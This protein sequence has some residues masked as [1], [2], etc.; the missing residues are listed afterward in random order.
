[1]PS[2]LTLGISDVANAN[3][4]KNVLEKI[5][6]AGAYDNPESV[7]TENE[8]VLYDAI[9]ANIAAETVRAENTSHLAKAGQIT[10][11]MIPFVMDIAIGKGLFSGMTKAAQKGVARGVVRAL[12]N[13]KW[14]RVL[15]RQTGNLI[16]GFA[17]SAAIAAIA[18]S[19]YKHILEEEAKVDP[20]SLQLTD[21]GWKV[22]K[23]DTQTT[24]AAIWNGY[25]GNF[26]E[27]FTETGGLTQFAAGF[28]KASPLGRLISKTPIGMLSRIMDNSGVGKLFKQ[29]AYHGIAGEM[30][31]EWEN[32]FYA[33]TE[34]FLKAPK[35][36]KLDAFGKVYGEFV[37]PDTQ[38]PMLISFS[39]PAILGGALTGTVHTGQILYHNAQYKQAYK[40]LRDTYMKYGA[41]EE[42]FEDAL[43]ELRAARMNMNIED[44]PQLISGLAATLSGG[45]QEQAEEFAAALSAYT[46][47]DANLGA[48]QEKHAKKQRQVQQ[49]IRDIQA[50]EERITSNTHTNGMMYHVT[51]KGSNGV[52]GYIVSGNVSLN[53]YENG[54]PTITNRDVVTV[55]MEDGSVWQGVAADLDMVDVPQSA[56][57]IS[58]IERRRLTAKMNNLDRFKV[59]D[60]IYITE[61]GQPVDGHS[62]RVAD[63]TDTGIVTD[64]IG[65]ASAAGSN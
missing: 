26:R 49:L 1:M 8:L 20:R 23:I 39:V 7:L 41:T 54:M 15:A 22:G 28:L 25:R 12:G 17:E 4:Q 30:S 45:S 36:E 29:T 50:S 59:G 27:I 40:N 47:A 53:E 34:A 16:G 61:N 32:T 60:V 14:R 24:G 6:N 55:K 38:V 13:G 65:G 21:D 19:T 18:P 46:V 44:Y 5:A 48:I 57:T 10:A 11:D 56:E 51:T 35:G 31:E 37:S 64:I 3:A 2:T 52:K 9:V 43:N 62:S 33:A 58:M 42:E 63:I